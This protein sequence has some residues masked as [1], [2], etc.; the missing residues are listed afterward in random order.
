MARTASK[1]YRIGVLT[2]GHGRGSNLKAMHEYF[3]ENGL[4][5]EISLVVITQNDSPVKALCQELDLYWE[6]IPVINMP[7]FEERLNTL[8]R[9]LNLDLIALAGFMRLLSQDFI[10]G[11]GIPI[12]NIHPALLPRFGGKG[13]YGMRVHEAV[14][15]SSESV[16]GAS[17]HIVDPI[18]DHGKITM[19]ESVDISKCK[20]PFDIAA[21]VLQVEHRIYAPAI[22]NYLTLINT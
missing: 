20:S 4:P 11:V 13:M 21:A 9:E 16:S 10:T 2:S 7:L 1:T 17:I 3:K 8:K 19:Q 12:L 6:L 18:Y 5:V 15:S 14:F 22:Y